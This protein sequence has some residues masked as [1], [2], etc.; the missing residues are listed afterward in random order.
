MSHLYDYDEFGRLSVAVTPTGR[1][2]TLEGKILPG[3]RP[4]VECDWDGDKFVIHVD[5]NATR[6]YFDDGESPNN[7]P[8]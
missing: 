7:V 2:L 3:A 5:L 8:D 6:A 1:R 4:F